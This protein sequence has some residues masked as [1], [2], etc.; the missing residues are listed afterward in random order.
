MGRRQALPTWERER[1]PPGTSRTGQGISWPAR[2]LRSRHRPAGR[3][4]VPVRVPARI[5]WERPEDGGTRER[6]AIAE[7]DL[8]VRCDR[9]NWIIMSG[10]FNL[11]KEF[12]KNRRER[13][14][15]T[16][17]A[18]PENS[19]IGRSLPMTTVG[20]TCPGIDNQNDNRIDNVLPR[21]KPFS[22]GP[23]RM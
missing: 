23:I 14:S 21:C 19:A 3:P 6:Q 18:T 2:S 10:Y 9:L 5:P 22:V 1:I 13:I 11:E 17:N 16:R 8:P 20:N 15:Y 7:P 4:D 12:K